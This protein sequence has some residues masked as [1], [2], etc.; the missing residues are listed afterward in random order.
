MRLLGIGVLLAFVCSGQAQGTRGGRAFV[1]EPA[2]PP[3]IVRWAETGRALRAEIYGQWGATSRRDRECRLPSGHVLP[4]CTRHLTGSDPRRSDATLALDAGIVVI[5]PIVAADDSRP[6]F[7]WLPIPQTTNGPGLLLRLSRLA[8]EGDT[9]RCSVTTCVR[10]AF[11][12]HA[13]D[14]VVHLCEAARIRSVIGPPESC[15]PVAMWGPRGSFA[16]ALVGWGKPDLAER[17]NGA[18]PSAVFSPAP[19]R[20]VELRVQ[21]ASESQRARIVR[22]LARALS[23]EPWALTTELRPPT[24]P[25]SRV[26]GLVAFRHSP[27]LGTKWE[28]VKVEME[29]DNP[30]PT[31]GGRVA[32][33]LVSIDARN[34]RQNV[35]DASG[36]VS[37]SDADYVRYESALVRAITEHLSPH[38]VR[39]ADDRTLLCT[40]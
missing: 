20:E 28:I 24:P 1:V 13:T 30:Q 21:Y 3:D 32:R 26:L 35:A 31:A 14:T 5:E 17:V 15:R 36:F 11:S 22:E 7:A 25:H 33:L 9:V 39:G 27:V 38:C 34:S 2:D 10:P 16:L 6:Y 40:S 4:S 37:A 18:A 29:L 8:A 19:V 12:V 23:A